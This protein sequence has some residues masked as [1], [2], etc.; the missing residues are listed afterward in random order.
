MIDTVFQCINRHRARDRI[1]NPVFW[2]T[3]PLVKAEFYNFV[4]SGSC[5]G[6]N[7]DH[8]IRR[9]MDAVP[10]YLVLIADNHQIRLKDKINIF[11]AFSIFFK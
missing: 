10:V 6:K 5:R 4:I 8:Q 7:L 9:T 3:C 2:D 11:R 1:S